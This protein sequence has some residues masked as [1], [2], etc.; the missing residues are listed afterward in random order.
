MSLDIKLALNAEIVKASAGVVDNPLP[1]SASTS[2]IKSSY[3]KSSTTEWNVAS[4]TGTFQG[5]HW[6]S[7]LPRP[8]SRKKLLDDH[9]G[10]SHSGGSRTNG[11]GNTNSTTNI[12]TVVVFNANTHEGSSLVRVL[13]EKGL[14]V[15]AV[16]RVFTSRNTK[17]L[18]KLKNVVV[19][20]ADLNNAEAVYQAAVNCQQAFLVTKYWERFENAIEEQMAKVVLSASA[21][22]GIQRLILATF[23]DTKELRLRNRKS[24]LM[25]T[26]D[27]RIFPKFTGMESIDYMGKTVGV[28]ITHMF[29]SFLDEQ[30]DGGGKKSIILIRGDN[31]KIILQEHD[32]S[33]SS[34][35]KK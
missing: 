29:T 17:Q 2:I 25:P 5:E 7:H 3:K 8:P 31:G 6:P 30:D 1:A 23:E 32:Q 12:P 26:V 20:V 22:A 13:S 33:S 11:G 35:S 34:S 9:N 28:S 21:T 10:S 15:T 18:I 4:E 16:V 24:Q 19:K 14:K 27:G